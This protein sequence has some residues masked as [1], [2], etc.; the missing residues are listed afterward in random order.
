MPA[1]QPFDAMLSEGITV[2]SLRR[3]PVCATLGMLLMGCGAAAGQSAQSG[4]PLSRTRAEEAAHT[5]QTRIEDVARALQNEPRP[6]NTFPQNT[7]DRVELRLGH[8]LFTFL[9]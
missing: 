2:E 9:H 5:F 8:T 7:T 4:S 3:L 1:A 6:K